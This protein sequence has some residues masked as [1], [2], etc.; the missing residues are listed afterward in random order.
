MSPHF[1]TYSAWEEQDCALLRMA[2][3]KVVKTYDKIGSNRESLTGPELLHAEFSG[4][5]I[6]GG[7]ISH[8]PPHVNHLELVT[9]LSTEHLELWINPFHQGVS[10]MTSI[11]WQKGATTKR[12]VTCGVYLLKLRENNENNTP[13][14]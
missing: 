4:H 10:L 3:N 13:K 1:F 12:V 2:R 14:N 11:W 7:L 6:V 5:V 8:A 9:P